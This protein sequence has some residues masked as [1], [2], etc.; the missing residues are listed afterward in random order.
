MAGPGDELGQQIFKGLSTINEL[1][2]GMAS[3]LPDVPE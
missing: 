1:G 3:A 2:E